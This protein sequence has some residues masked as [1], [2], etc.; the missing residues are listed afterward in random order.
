MKLKVNIFTILMFKMMILYVQA[1][2]VVNG[3]QQQTRAT[4]VSVN[5]NDL[6]E[7]N[8]NSPL[9]QS[10][11]QTTQFNE[12]KRLFMFKK[13]SLLFEY[14]QNK[15]SFRIKNSSELGMYECGF[16]EF[17]KFGVSIYKVQKLWR[18]QLIGK[19]AS[20]LSAYLQLAL[21]KFIFLEP[22]TVSNLIIGNKMIIQSQPINQ[23]EH[24]LAF[25]DAMNIFTSK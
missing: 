2:N 9:N 20:F 10:T 16:Y 12:E 7:L 14:N 5:F 17:D 1:R 6:I 11:N 18:V 4:L 23:S 21:N 24:R 25:R 19:M 22:T 8:C 15:V 3:T 13:N